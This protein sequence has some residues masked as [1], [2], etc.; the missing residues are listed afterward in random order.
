MVLLSIYRTRIALSYRRSS[1]HLSAFRG[2]A[3]HAPEFRIP[4]IDF[5]R[6]KNATSSNQKQET[7]ND[8]VDGFKT[9]GFVYIKNHGIP[10]PVI[11]NVFD[12]VGSFLARTFLSQL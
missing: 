6:Y 4:V 7:A 10:E 3:T 9:A 11:K 1:S 2:L 5:S 12:K 8:I